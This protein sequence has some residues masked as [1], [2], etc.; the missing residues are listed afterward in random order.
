GTFN[1]TI[2]KDA[3]IDSG[4][5]VS[6]DARGY[7]PNTGPGSGRL[8]PT[9]SAGSGAGHGGN[10]GSRIPLTGGPVPGGI[11]YDTI[12]SPNSPGSGGYGISGFAGGTGG[13]VI[14]L[15]VTGNLQL[16]GR[17]SADATAGAG[18]ATGGG[19]G[20]SI[21]LTLGGISGTGIIS[22]N[23]GAGASPYGGGGGG[24]RITVT[25][26]SNSFTG[27]LQAR[28]G[29]GIVAGGAG[30]IYSKGLSALSARLVADNGGL[31]G[32]NT[33]FNLAGVNDALIS[34]GATATSTVSSVTLSNLIVG[35]NSSFLVGQSFT[36][37]TTNLVVNAGGVLSADG[38]S[39]STVGSGGNGQT[40]T[41]SGG[42]GHGGFGG[43]GSGATGGSTFDT[44]AA[45]S[46]PGS[47]G[48]VFGSSFSSGGGALRINANT[49]QVD[50]RISV[51]GQAST[52]NYNG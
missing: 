42:A 48:G 26:A 24:G 22:A 13:G 40:G 23:G 29:P 6:M 38:A 20:G 39:S 2:L 32:T 37:T 21:W 45:P 14:R 17:L 12:A 30:T 3:T 31:R 1:L 46:S 4:S 8:N 25:W 7:A 36:F 27:S 41:G 16:N 49:L 52:T 18:S 9:G 19:A 50:A 34:G 28:G 11:T 44:A 51:N 10:G 5:Q 15:T 47:R 33:D 43:R 35:S